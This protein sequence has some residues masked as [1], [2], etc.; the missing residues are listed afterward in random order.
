MKKTKIKFLD[1]CLN[2]IFQKFRH[3]KSKLFLLAC[4]KNFE[5]KKKVIFCDFLKKSARIYG[6]IWYQK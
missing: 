1:T 5:Q 3:F 2:M 6:E 4:H